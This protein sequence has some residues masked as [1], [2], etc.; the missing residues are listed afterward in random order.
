MAAADNV[1]PE[2]VRWA[3]QGARSL[4]RMHPH[5]LGYE[6]LAY[7][8]AYYRLVTDA[9]Q[10]HALNPWALWALMRQESFYDPGAVSRAG[11]LGLMQ[12]MPATM[13]R[14]VN[15][16]G[17]PAMAAD[18]LFVPRVNIAMGARYFADRLD[19]F[20]GRL[21]P[22]LASYNAGETKCWQWLKQADGDAEEVFI[23]TIGYPETHDYVR[24]ILWL[25]W[26]YEAY[27]GAGSETAKAR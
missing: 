23:E 13:Q 4:P 27:Y 9:A 25:T 7:P 2:G 11:A 8:A 20:S 12:V 10:R 5:R 21:L 24:R 14:L 17:T 3:N 16:S 19:E 15:A 22:T 18:A 1:Y 26:V 6:R